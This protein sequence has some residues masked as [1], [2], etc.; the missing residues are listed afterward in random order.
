MQKNDTTIKTKFNKKIEVHFDGGMITSDAGLVLYREFEERVPFMDIIALHVNF[1]RNAAVHDDASVV[2]G[3]VYRFIAGYED[4]TDA[5]SLSS[6]P[7][8]PLLLDRDVLASQPTV[9]RCVNFY[10]MTD[11]WAFQRGNLAVVAAVEDAQGLRDI[12]LDFD[13]TD[14]PTHGCQQGRRNNV[15][16]DD[17]IRQGMFCF[18]NLGNCVKGALMN[19]TVAA[20]QKVIEFCKSPI[21]HYQNRG[22]RVRV[23]GDRA[24]GSESLYDWCEKRG[25]LYYFRLKTQRAEETL[26]ALCGDTLAEDPRRPGVFFGEYRNQPVGWSRA[27]RVC[28]KIQPK[29]GELF[30]EIL[31]V[32]TSDETTAPRDVVAFYED[33]GA[34]EN[35]IKEGKNGFFWKRLSHTFFAASALRLQILMLAYNVNNML[36]RFCMPDTMRSHHIQTLRVKIIKIGARVVHTGRRFILRCAS[37]YPFK[38]IFAQIHTGILRLQTAFG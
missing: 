34:C 27:R 28:M 24:F 1:R 32:V 37:A 22:V 26:R 36:R 33:R 16:Y 2:R 14:I 7:L 21:R 10:N 5:D 11:V 4:D 12:T 23:R 38:Y 25:V 30:P 3:M 9:S 29:A 19:G 15:F 20:S 8:L 17:R 6:D 31:C 18:N 35:Y 13:T